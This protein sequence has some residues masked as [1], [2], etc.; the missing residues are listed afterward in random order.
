MDRDLIKPAT[1]KPRQDAE[2][3]ASIEGSPKGLSLIGHDKLLTPVVDDDNWDGD[4]GTAHTVTMKSKAK[5]NGKLLENTSTG[6]TE[7][8]TTTESR[9]R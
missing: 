9:M 8:K 6:F 7:T 4:G 3:V 2:M 1:V 5:K